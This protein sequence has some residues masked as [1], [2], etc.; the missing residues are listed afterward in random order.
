MIPANHT[1]EQTKKLRRLVWHKPMFRLTVPAMHAETA[2]R[3]SNIHGR[4]RAESLYYKY[5]AAPVFKWVVDDKER[6]L[7]HRVMAV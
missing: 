4:N 1:Y 5:K 2:F 6:W 3:G 7:V